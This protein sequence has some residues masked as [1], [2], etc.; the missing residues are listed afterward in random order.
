MTQDPV[1]VKPIN[2]IPEGVQDLYANGFTANIGNTDV[3]VVLNKN[4]KPVYNLNMS[5]TFAKTLA[6]KLDVLIKH[7]EGKTGQRIMTSD[8]VVS[9]L[10]LQLEKE[11][12][13]G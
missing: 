11:K 5:Y 1:E 7:L 6:Q 8:E 13:P 10:K 4:G 2:T 3:C 12:G 9:Q